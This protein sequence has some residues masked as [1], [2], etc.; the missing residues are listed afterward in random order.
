MDRP[1]RS[2]VTGISLTVEEEKI[3]REYAEKE[4]RGNFSAAAGKIVREWAELKRNQK[5]TQ[6]SG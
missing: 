5:E 2:K 4:M 3:I 1:I 6:P